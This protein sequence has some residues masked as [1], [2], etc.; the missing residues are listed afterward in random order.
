MNE[1]GEY[2]VARGI[3]GNVFKIIMEYYKTGSMHC[4]PTVSYFLFKLDI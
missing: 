1:S 4:P 2:E 3:S